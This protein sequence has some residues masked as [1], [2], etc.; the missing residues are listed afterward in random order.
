MC[1]LDSENE[2][3]IL[4]VT[5]TAVA[6]K[7]TVT[8]QWTCF[9]C[10]Q[11]TILNYVSYTSHFCV[12]FVKNLFQQFWC[13]LFLYLRHWKPSVSESLC[14]LMWPSVSDSVSL[15]IPNTLS[16]PYLKNRW[17]EFHPVLFTDV[18]GFMDVL[19]RFR[20]EKIKG[21]SHSRQWPKKWENTISS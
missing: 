7:S 16:T 2:I 14:I 9:S 11:H 15:C 4:I 5:N 1:W 13:F 20:G 3:F 8:I 10:R 17:R 19:I 18:F 12:T 21:Q 6:S